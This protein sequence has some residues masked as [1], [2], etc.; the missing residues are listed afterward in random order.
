MFFK[1]I[2][3]RFPWYTFV[4]GVDLAMFLACAALAGFAI[5]STFRAE[6]DWR[7]CPW[8]SYY[9]MLPALT[10]TLVIRDVKSLTSMAWAWILAGLLAVFLTP[11]L[12][13]LTY[14]EFYMSRARSAK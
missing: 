8:V 13:S 3:H 11:Y 10:S 5:A 7:T 9:L 2:L 6:W 1:P 4:P 14:A 12:A